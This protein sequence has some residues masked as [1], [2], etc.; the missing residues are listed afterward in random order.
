LHNPSASFY[1]P[2]DD[3]ESIATIRRALERGIFFLDTAD[4][5]GPH[6]NEELV[7]RAIKGRR[8]E[9]TLPN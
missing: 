6:K 9:V 1:G 5:Y 3:A 7:G 8:D 2:G 4:V